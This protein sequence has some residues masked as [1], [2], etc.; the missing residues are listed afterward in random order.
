MSRRSDGRTDQRSASAPPRW[1][2]ARLVE[3]S[4]LHAVSLVLNAER[5]MTPGA[6]ISGFT[7]PPIGLGPRDEKLAIR[8]FGPI[9]PAA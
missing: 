9:A 1:A 8:P 3:L 5:I 6:A 4:V 2:A 7:E